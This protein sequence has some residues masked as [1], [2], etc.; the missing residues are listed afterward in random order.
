MCLPFSKSEQNKRGRVAHASHPDYNNPSCSHLEQPVP[1]RPNMKAA[2]LDETAHSNSNTPPRHPPPPTPPKDPNSENNNSTN[3]NSNSQTNKRSSLSHQQQQTNNHQQQQQ[4]QQPQSSTTPSSSNNRQHSESTPTLKSIGNYVLQQSLG[5]G[6]MGKVK[7]GVHNVTGEKVAIKIVPRANFQLSVQR[8]HANSNKSPRQIAK[9]QAREH[10]REMRTIREAHIMMLL[11]HP[12]IVGL[13]DMVISG[14]YFYISMEYVNGGQL[15]HY[16][17]KRQRL[18]ERRARHF[19]RQIISALDYMHRNSIV[20]RDLKIENILIDKAGRN[21]KLI[22]FGLSNLFAPEKLLTTYCG[23]LYFAAPELL[24]AN[25]YKGPEIDVWSM[26]VVI[27]VMVTGAVPFD[28][29]SMPGLHEK[30]KRGHVTYPQHMSDECRHLLTQIFVTDPTKRV[31]LQDVIRHPWL[32][33][34]SNTPLVKNFVPL[35]RKPLELPLDQTVLE[36]MTHGFE[37][38]TAEEIREKLEV[39]VQSPVYQE[40]AYHIAQQQA[41]KPPSP[42]PMSSEERWT[43]PYDDPQSVPDAYHPLISLY[44]LTKERIAEK[45]DSPTSAAPAL[46]HH[47]SLSRK[48]SVES[49]LSMNNGGTHSA[50]SSQ[51]SLHEP[52]GTTE[53]HQA[54]PLGPRRTVANVPQSDPPVL[55]SSLPNR[56]D[57]QLLADA[58]VPGFASQPSAAVGSGDY[59]SRFQRWLRSST[60]Q[61]HLVE[62]NS[63]STT[64]A[65]TKPPPSPSP[66]QQQFTDPKA[67]TTIAPPPHPHYEQG[68]P[69]PPNSTVEEQSINAAPSQQQQQH[70]VIDPPHIKRSL[71]RKI[72]HAFLRKPSAPVTENDVAQAAEAARDRPLPPLPPNAVITNTKTTTTMAAGGQAQEQVPPQED[73]AKP[74]PTLKSSVKYNKDQAA[75]ETSYRRGHH[76]RS[77]SSVSAQQAATRTLSMKINAWL[78]RSSSTHK[79]KTQHF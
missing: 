13:K 78:N 26:G 32:N 67:T 41:V 22:D 53:Q 8:I 64:T 75:M 44:Y 47:T 40:A 33:P 51:G 71:F 38:G 50:R 68:L 57:Y 42:P 17:I 16:I 70:T 15:L 74:M 39:I 65:S 14:P 77:A 36:Q 31:I 19:S 2:F 62:E 48:A 54:S 45:Q 28:D 4:H 12:H 34:D 37:L 63:N 58:S 43:I 69:T 11:R 25:P 56:P 10:N 46:Q 30:I 60:S 21:V 1:N 72:S 79:A 20:H 9:E 5:K 18:S 61:H 76:Q 49:T 29:K 35:S 23:S 6:S 24:R 66:L 52:T 27:Y 59:L 73:I 3:N 55:P 7:L